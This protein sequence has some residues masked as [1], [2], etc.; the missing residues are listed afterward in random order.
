M[1]RTTS[2]FARVL[3]NVL[4]VLGVG[5]LSASIA[6]PDNKAKDRPFDG[7]WQT[8]LSCVN[9]SGALG[10]S[11]KFPSSIKEGVLHGQKGTPHEAGW[12]VIDGPVAANGAADLYVDGLVGA[13]ATAVGQR[14]AGTQY[15]YHVSAQF[16]A[17]RGEGH[18]VEGRP[19]T[20]VFERET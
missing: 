5:L 18:R 6:R 17:D 20:V 2:R 14:A 13:S 4:L 3:R 15:G 16:T 19:C 8:T 9:A 1:D 12:L 11:F 7:I 10:Y